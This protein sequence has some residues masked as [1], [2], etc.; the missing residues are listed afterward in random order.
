MLR[1]LRHAVRLLI[2]ARGWTAVVVLSLAL[3]IGANTALFTAV[4][5]MLLTKIPVADPDTLVRFRYAGRNDMVTSSSDYGFM[6]KMPDGQNVRSTF[7][8]PMFRQ[9]VADNRT[10]KDL[11]ACAPFGRVNVVVDG[12]A[13]LDTAFI[14]S[15]NYFQV[16]GVRARAG[17]TILPDDDRADAPPVAVISS[18][19]WHTRFGTDAATIGRAIKVNNVPVTIV[20]ILPPEFTGIQQPIAEPP[21]ISLP[22]ALQPQL[23]PSAAASRLTQP[24]Y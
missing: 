13:Q 17:R 12:Q 20:G 23:D 2:A 1:D 3:G 9:F 24:T 5:G 4:N 14:V 18:R 19:Y 6:N 21:D 15:G 22:L 8:Y 7:S 16:L 10:L 11:L